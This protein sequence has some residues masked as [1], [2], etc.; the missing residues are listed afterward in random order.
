[1]GLAWLILALRVLFAL[2]ATVLDMPK[3]STKRQKLSAALRVL[4][5]VADAFSR[6]I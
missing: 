1:M 3:E 4:L 5:V 2:S 6:L